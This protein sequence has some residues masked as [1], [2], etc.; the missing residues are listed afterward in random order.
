[1]GE[2]WFGGKCLAYSDGRTCVGRDDHPPGQHAWR[3]VM[4]TIDQ[5]EG[6]I[7]TSHIQRLNR[8]AL[9]LAQR[10]DG[11][12]SSQSLEVQEGQRHVPVA[13]PQEML[14]K[15]IT[16]LRHAACELEAEAEACNGWAQV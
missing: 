12:S 7:R 9:D 1:V 6:V 5:G 14:R 15:A 3:S 11:K 13:L 8:H 16:D 10:V 4:G 2:D